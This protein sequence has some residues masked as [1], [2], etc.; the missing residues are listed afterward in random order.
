M[1]CHA[2]IL[3]V[4]VVAATVGC[5]RSTETPAAPAATSPQTAF[6]FEKQVGIASRQGANVGCLAIF[7]DA[8]QP[9]VKVVL[10]DQPPNEQYD[11]PGV[12]EAIIVERVSEPCDQHLSASHDFEGKESYYKIRSSNAEWQGNGYQFAIVDPKQPLSVQDGKVAG[13]IDGDGTPESFRNCSSSEGVHY[14]VWT[15]VPLEGRGRWHWYVYAG[16]DLEYNCTEKDYF[17]PK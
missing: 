5:T 9:G 10:A 14:Q 12:R 4:C 6:N 17:G 7:N 1:T 8:L 2:G 3:S 13:D 15:G 11:K 16:Y